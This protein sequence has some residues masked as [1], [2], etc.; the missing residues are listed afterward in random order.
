MS[1]SKSDDK[2]SGN[3]RLHLCRQCNGTGY[4]RSPQRSDYRDTE[5]MDPHEF[6][7]LVREA[8]RSTP[9]RDSP[10]PMFAPSAV[11]SPS[12]PVLPR[13]I[14]SVTFPPEPPTLPDEGWTRRHLA[15]SKLRLL[16]IAAVVMVVVLAYVFGRLR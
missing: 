14:A 10:A 1:D 7:A 13:R 2:L 8:V 5:E 15:A 4:V 16:R 3:H 6:N 9:P 11:P 12:P